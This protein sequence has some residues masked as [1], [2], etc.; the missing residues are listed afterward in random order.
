VAE[1][2]E[3]VAFGLGDAELCARYSRL[4]DSCR[5]AFIQQS[6][7]WA[8]VIAPL[9]PDEPVFL[10][11]SA[12]G[13]D[14]AGLPLYL[15]CGLGG[16]IL[17]SVPQPG[18]LGGVFHLPNVDRLSVYRALLGAA[19]EIGRARDCL[20][21]TVI[22]NPLDDDRDLYRRY[23]APTWEFTNFTQVIPLAHAVT[24]GKL[25]I[26]D[27][28][29]RNPGR[30][31][32]KA[33]RAGFTTDICSDRKSFEEW[34]EV[35]RARHCELGLSPLSH[36]L[37]SRLWSDLGP[38][39]RAFLSLVRFGR[40]IA[41]GCLFVRHRDV[42]DAFILSTRSKYA[43]L[44]PNYLLLERALLLMAERGVAAMN[45][46]SSPRRGDGVYRFK[47]Q[48]G[49]EEKAYAFVTRCLRQST[50]VLSIGVEGA[51]LGYRNHFLAPLE[52]LSR[53]LISGHFEK[54]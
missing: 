14:I 18:P 22:T 20:A 24:D 32:R 25:I 45:W 3:V 9:G 16:P 37:L 23:L 36:E 27:N 43:P 15:F 12:H 7:A 41:S 38:S 1:G 49:S 51:R 10:L 30:T 5:H 26:P 33:H 42:C 11:G 31:I 2:V 39:G 50:E 8:E 17:T 28:K 34:Y 52:A 54:E 13:R 6:V 35:H 40:E 48:W 4:H 53:N 44:A 46:Q 47:A 29:D 21:L 19:V